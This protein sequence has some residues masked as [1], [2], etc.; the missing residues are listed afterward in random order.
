MIETLARIVELQ[1]EWSADNTPAM[2]ERGTLVRDD[3][4]VELG[5]LSDAFSAILNIPKDDLGIIGSD[6]S[7][8]KTAIPWIRIYSKKRSPNPQTGWYMVILFHSEGKK[9]YLAINHGATTWTGTGFEKKPKEQMRRLTSWA[10]GVLS[11]SFGE[12]PDLLPEIELGA[13]GK[14]GSAYEASA[15]VAKVYHADALPSEDEFRS[16]LLLFAGL[17]H[18][19]YN[20]D[21]LGRSPDADELEFAI[22]QEEIVTAMR[23]RRSGSGQG[24]GLTADERKAVEVHAMNVVERHF[25]SQGYVCENKSASRPY[26][27]VLKKDDELIIVEVKGTT[28]SGDHILMTS[29]EVAA[30]EA[31]FPNNAL[32][33]VR[34]IDLVRQRNGAKPVASGGSL[35]VYH[36]WDVK[37]C[38]RKAIAYQ[39]KL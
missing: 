37:S 18:R 20:E 31:Y 26:D 12:H 2:Q 7:G 33:L 34:D 39:V 30:H 10:R 28:S 21:D 13:N 17:L 4:R 6:G 8:L 16:D 23:G 9:L 5:E 27:F 19:I 29:N 25:G 11:N 3:L 32:C 35:T 24:F 1:Q 38:E 36:A 15:P 14:L 22:G